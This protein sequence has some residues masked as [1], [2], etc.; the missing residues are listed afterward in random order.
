MN[1]LRKIFIDKN[2]STKFNEL[3]YTLAN[4]NTTNTIP[5]IAGMNEII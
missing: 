5:S 1:P 3:L 4:A 2:N